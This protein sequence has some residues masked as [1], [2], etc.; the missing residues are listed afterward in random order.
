MDNVDITLE[1]AI[2]WFREPMFQDIGK[3]KIAVVK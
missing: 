3:N 1:E 2:V